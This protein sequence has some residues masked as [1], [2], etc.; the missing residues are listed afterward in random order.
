MVFL[1]SWQN[2]SRCKEL[3]DIKTVLIS[4]L[5]QNFRFFALQLENRY[6]MKR[7]LLFCLVLVVLAGLK[8]AFFP[9]KSSASAPKGPPGAVPVNVKV[10]QTTAFVQPFLLSGQ[11]I[12]AEQTDLVSESAGK[13]ILLNYNEGEAV[14][15]GQLLAKINDSEWQAELSKLNAQEQLAIKSLNRLRE[16]KKINGTSEESIDQA[17]TALSTLRSEI[18]LLKARI[19]KTEI[20]APYDGILGMRQVSPGAFLGSQSRIGSIV[21]TNPLR[22]ECRLPERLSGQVRVGDTLFFTTEIDANL[23]YA[24]VLY[25]IEPS[26]SSTE[27]S[28]LVRAQVAGNHTELKPGSSTQV[29]LQTNKT[30]EGLVVPAQSLV[31]VQGG[32]QVFVI[33]DGKAEP[34]PIKIKTRTDQEVLVESGLEA[35]DSLITTGIMALKKGALVKVKSSPVK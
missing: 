3:L 12:A 32:F 31:A 34:K 26:V 4:V 21:K 28:L 1:L 18:A 30:N 8:W 22:L 19:E 35:G 16:L 24:S 27:R 17:E 25:A 14:K 29:R 6:P 2:K 33:K 11:L 13:L 20:R 10:L 5:T 15:K 7:I 23:T 9:G